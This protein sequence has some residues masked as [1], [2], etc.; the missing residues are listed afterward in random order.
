M[1]PFENFQ[2]YKHSE[3]VLRISFDYTRVVIGYDHALV[4]IVEEDGSRDN[5]SLKHRNYIISRYGGIDS[6]RF[7]FYNE[8]Y[9]D[10]LT[11][12]AD[13]A[14]PRDDHGRRLFLKSL[15]RPLGA[16]EI[17]INAY[18]NPNQPD[19]GNSLEF[20]AIVAIVAEAN[21]HPVSV[22]G[23]YHITPTLRNV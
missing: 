5:W 8:S 11:I 20:Y 16:D 9:N 10:W 4:L 6:S 2:F 23:D 18:Y 14:G 7:A 19:R 13:T 15:P 17:V 1:L 22:L 3:G 12:P 21:G